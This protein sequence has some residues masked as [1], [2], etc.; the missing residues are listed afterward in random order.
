MRLHGGRRKKM[1]EGLVGEGDAGGEK[2]LNFRS[3]STVD[4]TLLKQGVVRKE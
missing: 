3:H 1:L 4:F 2:L